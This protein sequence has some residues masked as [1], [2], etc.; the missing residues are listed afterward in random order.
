MSEYI[1][2]IFVAFAGLFLAT[3][4][5]HKKRRKT[6]HLICPL[7]GNCSEVIQSKYSKF[8]GVPVEYLGMLYYA[9]IALGY[10]AVSLYP[11]TLEWLS[12]PLFLASIFAVVF[13]FYLTFIQLV[14][15]QKICT[16]CLL[17]ATFCLAIFLLALFGGLSTILPFLVEYRDAVTVLHVLSMALGLSAATFAD[18]FFFKFLKDYQISGKEAEVLNAFSQ[19]IWFAL[20]LI[21]MSG[22]ALYLPE[23]SAYNTS[24]KFLTKITILGILIVNGAFLTLFVGP[25]FFELRF[26]KTK[27][28]KKEN[29]FVRRMAFVLGPISIISWY[30]A[31]ILGS[32]RSIPISYSQAM[33]GYLLVVAVGI[34]AG[35][36]LERSFAKHAPAV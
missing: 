28:H 16:W 17:S 34:V 18:L 20:G 23:A 24:S 14:T 2:I 5:M 11:V 10:G 22:L 33:L 6:E 3:Y 35:L 1:V 13:S 29:T 30:S 32:L 25:R 8:L 31:F 36:L 12:L 4:L 7:K 21:V 15:L 26:L 9:V 19:V 27:A